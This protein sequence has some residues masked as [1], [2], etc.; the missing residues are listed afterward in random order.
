MK[1]W[2]I[3]ADGVKHVI[4][5]KKSFSKNI[6]IVD[7]DTY[8]V[9]SSN[10]FINLLDYGISFGSTEC[11]L[12][13]IGGKVD[14]AVNGT[15]LGSKQP[16]QPI[17]NAAPFIWVLVGISTLG[18]LILSGIFALIVGV[19]M[20]VLYIQ[21]GMKKKNGA[22]IGCFIGCTIIQLLIFCV[23]VAARM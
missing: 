20:S 14:L 17:S 3:E 19:L 9:K 1:K 10:M 8:K 2:E 18:G 16:Y 21:F 4:Q 7:D 6:I 12:V 22:V 5:Y 15:F 23:A 11:K 13:V